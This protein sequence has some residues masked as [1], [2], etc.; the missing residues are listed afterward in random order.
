MKKLLILILVQ[1]SINL[2]LAQDIEINGY[3]TDTL[4]NPLGY[5]NI[6]VLN[7]PIGTVSNLEGKFTLTI[8]K[9]H[10]NDTLR[11]SNLG[12]S[13]KDFIIN[14]IIK[15]EGVF[16]I[17]LIEYFE[18]LDEVVIKPKNLKSFKDGKTKVKTKHQVIFANPDLPNI[19]LGTEIGK[20][21]KLGNKKKSYLTSFKFYIK[22]NNFEFVKFRINVYNIINNKPQKRLNQNNIFT[23][24]KDS[25]T[26]W[27]EIDLSEYDLSVKENIIITVEWIEHS[28]KGDKLNL[29]IIIPSFGSKH[30][31]KFGAQNSWQKYSNISSSM[32]L[33][34][35]Q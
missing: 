12:F 21:F 30:Y 23:S 33:T 6:G 19:N 31:Y 3:V 5:A 27:L 32:E 4:N 13:Q 24:A 16:K 20:K 18:E 29:P 1:F 10:L 11:I 22:D 15:K 17:Q 25:Y 8:D 7:K 9:K 2:S 34:Y 35:E 14:Q 28:E 26:G